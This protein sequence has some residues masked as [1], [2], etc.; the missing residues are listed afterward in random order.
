MS[1]WKARR[2]WQQAQA[3][4]DGDGWGVTLDGKPLRTPG[5]HPLIVP[6]KALAQAIA[7]EWDAQESVIDPNS[8]PLT[9]AANSAIEKVRPQREEVALMLAEYGGTDLL[10]YRAD[11]P[12]DLAAREAKGWDPLIDWGAR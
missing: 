7:A 2:F 12:E 1:E 11:T 4:R 3:V 5:K 10:C 8:M 9:R 6:T